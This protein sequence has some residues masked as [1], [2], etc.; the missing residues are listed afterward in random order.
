MPLDNAARN[1]SDRDVKTSEDWSAETATATRENR[2]SPSRVAFLDVYRNKYRSQSDWQARVIAKICEFVDLPDG[3]DTY[4]GHP[5]RLETGMF[6]LKILQGV[7]ES[8]VPPP[9]VVPTANGGIQLEWHEADVDVELFIAAPYQCEL[10]FHDHHTHET[11]S[12]ELKSDY[13]PMLKFMK[14]IARL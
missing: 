10:W 2:S 6:A 3:W 14:R 4:S 12:I 1:L 8:A 7:M 5:V 9:E 11:E 13:A